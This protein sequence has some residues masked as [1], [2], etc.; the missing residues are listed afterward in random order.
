MNANLYDNCLCYSRVEI[1]ALTWRGS[2]FCGASSVAIITNCCETIATTLE[3]P[4]LVVIPIIYFLEEDE[5]K[6]KNA[7]LWRCEVRL[8]SS[9]IQAF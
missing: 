1:T 2:D 7:R 5:E 8:R 6:T 3:S 9:F 4:D